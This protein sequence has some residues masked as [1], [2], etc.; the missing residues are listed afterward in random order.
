MAVGMG[1]KGPGYSEHPR[2]AGELSFGQLRQLAIIAVGLI[3]PD[4]ADLR[5]DE[6]IVVEQP[7]CCR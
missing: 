1:D 2:I 3:I 6:V 5:L 4:R 7:F